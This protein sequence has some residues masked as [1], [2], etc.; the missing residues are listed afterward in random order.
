[1]RI[2]RREID[3]ELGAALAGDDALAAGRD[4]APGDAKRAK[5]ASTES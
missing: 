1:M 4:I 5:I 2:E 3:D